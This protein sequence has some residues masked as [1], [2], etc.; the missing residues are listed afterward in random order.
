VNYAGND[1]L[2][3]DNEEQKTDNDT[4]DLVSY[5]SNDRLNND[6]EELKSWENQS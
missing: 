4:V 5:A 6:N 2:N 1:R 3:N